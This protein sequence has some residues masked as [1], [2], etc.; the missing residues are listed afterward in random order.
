MTKIEL[1]SLPLVQMLVAVQADGTRL[2]IAQHSIVVTLG[3]LL[4]WLDRSDW[5]NGDSS[6]A[7]GLLLIHFRFLPIAHLI[8]L[9]LKV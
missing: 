1:L 7:C 9:L 6:I 5:L 2:R 8:N 4:I 3:T